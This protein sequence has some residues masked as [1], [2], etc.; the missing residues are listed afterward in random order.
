MR[1]VTLVNS[2]GKGVVRE[3]REVT[4]SARE[5]ESFGRDVMLQTLKE[6]K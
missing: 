1:D 5:K 2:R 6:G 3:G 4:D